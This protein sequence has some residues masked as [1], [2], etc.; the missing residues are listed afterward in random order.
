MVPSFPTTI[1]SNM[2]SERDIEVSRRMI[3]AALSTFKRIIKDE[4]LV[5]DISTYE[6]SNLAVQMYKAMTEV[7]NGS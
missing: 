7:R 5:G 4:R 2:P 3:E 6:R 1:Q